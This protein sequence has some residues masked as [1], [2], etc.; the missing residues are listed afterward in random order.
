MNRSNITYFKLEASIVSV[1]LFGGICSWFFEIAGPW[2]Y[3]R[4]FCLILLLTFL[5][6]LIILKLKLQKIFL[7]LYYFVW[8]KRIFKSLKHLASNNSSKENIRKFS[9]WLLDKYFDEYFDSLILDS[10]P[11]NMFS[12]DDIPGKEDDKEKLRKFLMDYRNFEWVKNAEIRKSDDDI[13]ISISKDKDS[14][15]IKMV[16]NKEKAILTD[17]DGKTYDLKVKEEKGKLNIY[18]E[19]GF[20]ALVQGKS[21]KNKPVFIRREHLMAKNFLE[22]WAFSVVVLFNEL[23]ITRRGK[24]GDKFRLEV[25]LRDQFYGIYNNA[26]KDF[27]ANKFLKNENG[28]ENDIYITRA[29]EKA[30]EIEDF[31]E[32]TDSRIELPINARDTPLRWA[33]GGV[34]PI[35]HWKENYWY[36]LFFRGIKPVGWNMAN[37]ASETTEEYKNLSNLMVREFSEE[38]ILLDREPQIDDPN[39]IG[40]K[41]FWYSGNIF[42]GLPKEIKNK[43]GSKEFIEKHRNLRK[44]HDNLLINYVKGPTLEQI[45]TP[46]EIQVTSHSENPEKTNELIEDVIFSVNPLEF[47]IE[48]ISLYKFE[49]AD[50]D[51]PIFGEIWEVANIPLR[52][53]VLFLSCEYVQEVFE[54]N[55]GSLGEHIM[56]DPSL[57]CKLLEKI[58][59][60]KYHIFGKDIE[61]RKRRIEQ[62]EEDQI[63][64][65][66]K[67]QIELEVH[68][69]WLGDYEDL[70]KGLQDEKEKC[71][72]EKNKHRQAAMLCPVTWKT[73]ESV[74]K[75]DIL[76]KRRRKNDNAGRKRNIKENRGEQRYDKEI[77]S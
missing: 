41:V 57:D 15:E 23:K 7:Y 12:W 48:S 13:T 66:Q 16:E 74:C 9:K 61:F 67:A 50:E 63:H 27:M 38:L 28:E 58:P 73:L 8:N 26:G 31:L 47:G 6:H 40:Q 55:G 54:N 75:Y 25:D 76:K 65:T 30:K 4:T 72:I 44:S 52:E 34:L 37:G 46:F 11:H 70:F 45:S 1:V 60:D 53:P 33:S 20:T 5:I 17:K 22:S 68:K 2:T 24:K 59:K 35:A 32:G 64:H 18:H 62:I 21:Y 19:E 42:N 39:P 71:D 3:F 77:W 14:A 49:M 51:Y 36:V 43:I 10:F 56:K 29:K 69:R